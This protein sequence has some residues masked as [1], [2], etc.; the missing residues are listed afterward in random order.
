M[1]GKGGGGRGGLETLLACRRKTEM[2]SNSMGHL[3]LMQG[4]LYLKHLQPKTGC[5]NLQGVHLKEA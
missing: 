3:K 5:D 2:S 1:L 4:L